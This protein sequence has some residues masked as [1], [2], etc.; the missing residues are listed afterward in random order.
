MKTKQKNILCILSGIF[1]LYLAVH[2]WQHAEKFLSE[3][4]SAA[5]P[6]I[7]A[8]AVAYVLNILMDFYEQHYFPRTKK[9]WAERSRRPVCL[10]GAIL[11]LIAIIVL[12]AALLIPQLSSCVSLIAAE[13]PGFLEKAVGFLTEKQLLPEDI[14]ASLSSID[15]RE[16]AGAIVETLVSGVGSIVN[17]VFSAAASLASAVT[18]IVLAIIFAVYLLLGK[19]RL[20]KQFSHFLQHYLREEWYNKIMSVLSVLNDSFHKFIVGQC[21]EAVILGVLCMFGMVMLQL[22]YSAMIGTL[23]AFTALIPVIGAFIGG[24]VGAFIILMESP[25]KALIFVI[26]LIIL[27]Q[28]EGNLIYPRVVGTSI[29]LPAIW[30]LAVVTVGGSVFGIFGILLGIPIAAAV[31]RLIQSDM[32]KDDHNSDVSKPEKLTEV[33]QPQ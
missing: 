27:Q 25:V 9:K 21:T 8:C 15:W 32:H 14:L 31:Y 1:L 10:I 20:G 16:K 22:P 4:F 13:L 19:E 30:V 28:L 3:L 24:A 12:V 6:I 17:V 11:T 33:Q 26:F 29:G 2:Y 7:L 5:S 18:T 23:V